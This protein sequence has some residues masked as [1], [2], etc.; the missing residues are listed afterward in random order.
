MKNSLFQVFV[1]IILA[2]FSAVI[3]AQH[4]V[5]IDGKTVQVPV[6]S[7]KGT[8]VIKP[9]QMS[10]NFPSMRVRSLKVGFWASLVGT[11]ET[12]SRT[13]CLPSNCIVDYKS[14]NAKGYEIVV[15][16]GGW[17]FEKVHEIIGNCLKSTVKV[18]KT[19]WF[20]SGG[21]YNQHHVIY[22]KCASFE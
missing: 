17:N 14:T 19:K 22:G 2:V 16:E 18:C 6:P 20:G 15:R 4:H 1:A 13:V 12:E 21:K 7:D 10:D 3:M 8:L 9:I 11:C 5:T